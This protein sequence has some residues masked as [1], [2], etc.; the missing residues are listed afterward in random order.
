M[1]AFIA[2]KIH[3]AIKDEC[4][5]YIYTC[6]YYRCLDLKEKSTQERCMFQDKGLKDCVQ[7]YIYIQIRSIKKTNHVIRYIFC[8]L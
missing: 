5:M 8:I 6:I 7:V 1:K 2:M 3:Y 4:F